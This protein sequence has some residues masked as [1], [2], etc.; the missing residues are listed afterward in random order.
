[1]FGIRTIPLALFLTTL[2]A[3]TATA[4]TATAEPTPGDF[5]CRAN[6]VRLWVS[7]P[8]EERATPWFA[9]FWTASDEGTVTPSVRSACLEL[10]EEPL[11]LFEQDPPGP[12]ETAPM[13]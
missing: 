8:Q 2:A 1:L 10:L 7:I 12:A 5:S 6:L 13:S 9:P 4:Q 11:V 3:G